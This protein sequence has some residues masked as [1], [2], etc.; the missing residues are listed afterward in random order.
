[1]LKIVL[2]K[3]TDALFFPKSFIY[4]LDDLEK[5]VISSWNVSY[6]KTFLSIFDFYFRCSRCRTVKYFAVY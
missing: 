2:F 5:D 1:M 3:F 6:F 4:G